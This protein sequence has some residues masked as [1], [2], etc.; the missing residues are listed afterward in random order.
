MFDYDL[1]VIGGGSG[2]VR[3]AR[4]A[5]GHGARV[6]LAE[7]YRLGGTCVIRGCVPKKLMVYASAF[8]DAFEDAQGYGWSVGET[9][10]DWARLIA[11]KDAEIARLEALYR[12]TLTKAGVQIFHCRA[13][14]AGPHEVTL[15]EGASLSAKHILIA[16][17]GR[18]WMPDLPGIEHAISSDDIFDLPEQPRRMLIVG[19]GY[20]AC[21]FA[22][23]M[24]GLGTQVRQFYRGEQILR[25]FDDDVR[26]HVAD[27]MRA[28]GVV[29]EVRRDVERIE[30]A[31]GGLRITADNVEVVLADVVL[32]ATGRDPNTEGLRLGELGCEV[33]ANGRVVV[34]EWSQTALPSIYAVGDVTERAVLTPA[35]IREGQAFA[36]TVFGGRRVPVDHALVPSGIFTQ[37]EVG[38]VGP[39]EAE[40]RA[41]G[42]ITVYRARFRPMLHILAGRDETMLMKLIVRAQ[43]HR[44]LACHVVGHGA[45]E[46]IQ[47]AA[48]AI[49]MGATKQDFD[50]TLA[51]HPTAAEELVT[52]RDPVARS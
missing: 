27:A 40:A 49:G 52:M 7:E 12:G 31:E 11:A 24:N 30:K 46:I 16:A 17:G 29:L 20:V 41:L 25:D 1:F 8:S 37:P 48:I 36:E 19:G 28:R 44:V 26:D 22:G 6:A 5:A 39:G 21:E 42:A 14:V 15:A 33:L 51:V 13:A 23:I 38:T 3:A 4:V 50:R 32:M 35:A 10:F 47:M 9:R 43:D 2:G 45:A 18:P 34:D